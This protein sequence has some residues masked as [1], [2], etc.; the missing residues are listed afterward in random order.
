MEASILLD[1]CFQCV[2]ACAFSMTLLKSN[3]VRG[4]DGFFEA[5]LRV[6]DLNPQKLFKASSSFT[7]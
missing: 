3:F 4:C 6:F 1:F 7:M 2:D 5:G